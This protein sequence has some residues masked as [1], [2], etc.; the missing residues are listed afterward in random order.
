MVGHA[1]HV[2]FHMSGDFQ[3]HVLGRLRVGDIQHVIHGGCHG[4]PGVVDLEAQGGTLW[5]GLGLVLRDEYP[6]HEL[7][8]AA[9]IKGLF[10]GF[11][12]IVVREFS[13]AIFAVEQLGADDHCG[14]II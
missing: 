13:L 5:L 3:A 12:R 8:A 1:G 10:V 4:D 2:F 11:P 7:L 9:G 14:I 6:L